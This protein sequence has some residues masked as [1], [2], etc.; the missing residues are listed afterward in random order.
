[1]RDKGLDWAA[2]KDKFEL[3]EEDI[4]IQNPKSYSYVFGGLKPLSI[5]FIELLFKRGFKGMGNKCK[6]LLNL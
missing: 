4:N 5:R 6:L 3:I 1:M 2:I